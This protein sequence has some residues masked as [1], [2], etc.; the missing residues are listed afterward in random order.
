MMLVIRMRR[1]PVPGL[2]HLDA[3]RNIKLG[4]PQNANQA[5]AGLRGQKCFD[6]WA[7]LDDDSSDFCIR[8]QPS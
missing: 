2:P 6:A 7:E 1:W 4:T 8:L 5:H 3:I